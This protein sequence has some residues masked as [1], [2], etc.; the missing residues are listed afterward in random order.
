[1]AVQTLHIIDDRTTGDL[2][3][4]LPT[5]WHLVTD[6]VM[7]G[8]SQGQLTPDTIEDRQC[9]RI[10]G[11][12]SLDN[13]G[14]FIQ[15]ALDLATDGTLDASDFDGLI[16]DV[17]GNSQSYNIHLRTSDLWLP[18]QSFRQSFATEPRWQSLKFPFSGF[19]AYRTEKQ[20]NPSHLKRIGIVAIGKEFH[21]DVCV[22]FLAFYR[23]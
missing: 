6:K 9:L 23:Q 14:G 5:Q 16:L 10:S 8:V 15:A 13:N 2:H 22:G 11:D 21:A 18:W 4:A 7:G 3:T 1:M 17:Y 20:F 12:V 19:E